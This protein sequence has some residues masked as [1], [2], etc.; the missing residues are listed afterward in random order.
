M[1]PDEELAPF[2]IWMQGL[3]WGEEEP[4]QLGLFD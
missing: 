1:T 2:Q 3:D 4:E